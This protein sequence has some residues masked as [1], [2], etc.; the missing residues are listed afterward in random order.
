M[1]MEQVMEQMMESLLAKV[2]EYHL[3]MIVE[4]KANNEKFE[5]P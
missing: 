3:E 2:R 5:A 4:L 1:K